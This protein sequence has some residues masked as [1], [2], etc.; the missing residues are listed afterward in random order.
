MIGYEI[1]KD[2]IT[3]TFCENKDKPKMHCNGKCHMHKQLKEQEKQDQSPNSTTKEKLEVIQFCKKD[4]TFT[5]SSFAFTLTINPFYS[6][7]P[8]PKISFSIFHPPTC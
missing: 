2:Y 8:L 1:N 4:Q 6:E 7:T 3:K 5:F